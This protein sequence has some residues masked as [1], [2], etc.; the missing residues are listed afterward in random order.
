[1]DPIMN[2]EDFY[3]TLLP[4]EKSVKDS[5]ATLQKLSRAISRETEAGDIRNLSRDL[6]ALSEAAEAVSSATER[7]RE[8][9]S[10]FDSRAYFESGDFVEQMLASCQ[11][12]GVDVRGDFPVYEMFPYRVR[13]DAEKDRKSTRLNSS[14]P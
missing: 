11:E 10:S 7:L 12:K 1:M 6:S 9:V 8:T 13:L 14:H 2:Y 5:L 4:L 3:Q